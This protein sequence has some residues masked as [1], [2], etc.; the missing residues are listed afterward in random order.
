ML[1]MAKICQKA[2]HEYAGMPCGIM[3]QLITVAAKANHALLIDC[4]SLNTKQIP[5]NSL[6]S[7]GYDLLV[8]DSMHKHE[9]TNSEYSLHR[10]TCE[11]VSSK[12]GKKSL[13]DVSR[14]EL[15]AVKESLQEHHYLCAKHVITEN[16]R[17][18]QAAE[19]LQNGD[20][21]LLGKL[22]NKSHLSLQNDFKVSTIYLDELVQLLNSQDGVLGARLTGAGFGGCV[23][24]IVKQS[25]IAAVS[26]YVY[27]QYTGKQK[28]EFYTFTPV[29]GAGYIEL[30][31]N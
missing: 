31:N 29:Q 25:H 20:F 19:A 21:V 22:M 13:R 4:R 6:L 1:R 10:Q 7:A 11:L 5:L 23:I 17:V 14:K 28:P 2:E 30:E 26:K 18:L 15:E 16:E 9:L 12:L 8:I 24:S 3:D 27:D